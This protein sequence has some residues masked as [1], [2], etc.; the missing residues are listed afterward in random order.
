MFDDIIKNS[1][2]SESHGAVGNHAGMG[3]FY[4]ALPYSL[5]ASSIVC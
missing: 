5:R 2:W 4:Y 1:K 3:I